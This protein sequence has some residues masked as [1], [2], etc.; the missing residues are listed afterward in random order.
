[1]S[2]ETHIIKLG[3]DP[4]FLP[5]FSAIREEINKSNHPSQPE[6]NWQLVESLALTLF[7]SNGVDL[8][9]ATYYTLARTK[10]NGLPGFCEGCELLAG[11]IIAEW[12][13]FWP[14][15]D[16]ARS[17]MLEWFNTRIGNI[18][19]QNPPLVSG[20]IQLLCRTEDTLQR[21]CDKLQQVELR[22]VPRVENLLYFIQN[23]RK[24]A[25][26]EQQAQ[27]AQSRHSLSPTLVYMPEPAAQATPVCIPLPGLEPMHQAPKVEV[28]FASPENKKHTSRRPAFCGFLAGVIFSAVICTGLW[29]WRVA[30]M[31]QQ[32]ARINDTVP[33]SAMLWMISPDLNVYTQ[34]L[35]GL[36]NLPVWQSLETGENLTKTAASVW[37]ENE[38]QQQ[39]TAR[40]KSAIQLRANNSPTLQ[41]YLQVQKDLHEFAALLLQRER[42]KEGVTLSYLKT[43][44]YQAETLLNQETPLEALVTQLEDAKR[45]HQNTQTLE[46]KIN[47]R[48][49]SLSSRYLLMRNTGQQ[50]SNSLNNTLN[51]HD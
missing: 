13:C 2:D 21:I 9:T 29:W 24:R 51:I 39:A 33:G 37:P 32:L 10:I 14:Q 4:R 18:L 46:E 25:G 15:N 31:Q 1:M 47:E 11:L 26:A 42:S 30:P 6:V 34:R 45:L 20:D 28:H 22:R 23:I 5:E 43:V 3:H 36:L 48:M 44:V 8:H 41:G 38:Q 17:D 40:W 50:N 49:D 7:K 16:Q 19:R 12:D 35:N 27:G